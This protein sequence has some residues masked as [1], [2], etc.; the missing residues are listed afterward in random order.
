[1]SR[2]KPSAPDE[3]R[4]EYDFS[5]LTGGVRAKYLRRYR[6]G[7]NL[8]LLDPDVAAAFPT[9]EAVNQALRTV[10]SA[11]S[12]IRRVRRPSNKTLQRSGG[13]G[14]VSDRPAAKR[15]AVRR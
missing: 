3:L 4:A 14:K 8:A 1:M 11:A 2:S 7:T 5:Q 13:A 9:D 10:L 6:A 12:A 15:R